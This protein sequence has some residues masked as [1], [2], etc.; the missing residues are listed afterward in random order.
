MPFSISPIVF[1]LALLTYNSTFGQ[2][3]DQLEGKTYNFST[4]F[5]YDKCEILGR[6]DCCSMELYFYDETNFILSI[7]CEGD[8]IYIKGEYTQ[9]LKKIKLTPAPTY[10]IDR[11]P[12]GEASP[13]EEYGTFVMQEYR[14]E[15]IIEISNCGNNQILILGEDIGMLESENE[16]LKKEIEQESEMIQLLQLN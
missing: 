2:T 5:D 3:I 7:P 4:D 16:Y 15:S 12:Y 6:C 10:V 8:L 1:I 13:D 9:D 11:T 14:D